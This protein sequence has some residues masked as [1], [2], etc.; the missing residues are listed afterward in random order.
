[1]ENDQLW[2]I[3][4]VMIVMLWIIWDTKEEQSIDHKK[5]LFRALEIVYGTSKKKIKKELDTLES[6]GSVASVKRNKH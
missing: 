1:M 6:F 4:F 3:F 5:S 2:G